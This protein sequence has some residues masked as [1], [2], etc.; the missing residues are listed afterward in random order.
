VRIRINSDPVGATVKVDMSVRGTTPLNLELSPGRHVVALQKA[1]CRD[2]SDSVISVSQEGSR[3]FNYKLEV[4]K[5]HVFKEGRSN[6]TLQRVHDLEQIW[7]AGTALRIQW[8]TGTP[9][10]HCS[11]GNA[12]FCVS[13]DG[14]NWKEI[15][16]G[17][18]PER[19]GRGDVVHSSLYRPDVA[20]RYVKVTI[21]NNYC[22]YSSS[23]V[24]W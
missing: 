24:N 20:Y 1:G 21:P 18:Y 22:D 13:T 14:Q 9:G 11:G 10:G 8:Q 4:A 23:E 19:S 2:V 12:T 15:G 16:S 6:F 5:R 3:Y 17:N 7:P